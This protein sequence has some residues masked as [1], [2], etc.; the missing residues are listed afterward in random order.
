MLNQDDLKAIGKLIKDGIRSLKED[1]E[2]VK[3]KVTRT[4]ARLGVIAIEVRDIRD[5]QSVLN[6]KVDESSA[7]LEEKVDVGFTHLEERIDGT[8]TYASNIED[9]RH[10]NDKRI[11]R[12][13]QKLGLTAA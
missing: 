2:I 10:K 8:L 11:T 6:E 13:E 1:V 3:S 5:K 9:E 4:D 12:L 7:R